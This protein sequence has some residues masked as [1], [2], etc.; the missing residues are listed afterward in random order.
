MKKFFLV[1]VALLALS[2]LALATCGDISSS[3]EGVVDAKIIESKVSLK[4]ILEDSYDVEVYGGKDVSSPTCD[5]GEEVSF[6]KENGQLVHKTEDKLDNFTANYMI[7]IYNGDQFVESYPVCKENNSVAI[8]NG[9][10][11]LG[12]SYSNK[13]IEDEYDGPCRNGD[14]FV[15]CE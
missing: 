9:D 1:T 4:L 14:Q 10:Q 7:C 2:N 8:Y 12:T 13:D 5:K 15:G 11:Y 3:V 6:V